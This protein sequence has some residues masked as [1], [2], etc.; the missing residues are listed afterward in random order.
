MFSELTDLYNHLGMVF[1]ETSRAW[2]VPQKSQG[3]MAM[4][5]PRCPNKIE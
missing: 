3:K 4:V 5:E 1:K 2:A